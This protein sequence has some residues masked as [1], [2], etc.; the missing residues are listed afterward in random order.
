M[1]TMSTM[2]MNQAAVNAGSSRAM[3]TRHLDRGPCRDHPE[4]DSE[5]TARTEWP[6]SRRPG[7]NDDDG[8]GSTCH[9]SPTPTSPT[10]GQSRTAGTR[11]R[12][13]RWG[14]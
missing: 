7:T 8:D 13:T 2:K 1:Q 6:V 10:E 5:E 12:P 11:N 3:E 14:L 4:R 9:A